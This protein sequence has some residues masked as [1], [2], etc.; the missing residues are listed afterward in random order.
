MK[1]R[2]ILFIIFIAISFNSFSQYVNVGA[3][4]YYGSID[5]NGYQPQTYYKYQCEKDTLINGDIYSKIAFTNCPICPKF[6]VNYFITKQNNKIYYWFKNGKRLLFDLN[7]KVG[8]TVILDVCLTRINKVGISVDSFV[9]CKN[10]VTQISWK[11]NYLNPNDSLKSIEANNNITQ[12]ITFTDRVIN[13][14]IQSYSYSILSLS[15]Y[16]QMEGGNYLSCYSDS[17]YSYKDFYRGNLACDY[18]NTGINETSKENELIEVFPNPANNEFTI[19]TKTAEKLNAQLFDI[20][21]KEVSEKISFINSATIIT[22]EISNGIYFLKITNSN[23]GLMKMQKIVI[24][25]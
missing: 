13:A 6:S 14:N 2:K 23:F 7:A 3:Q 4:W 17:N 1:H 10:V 20:T 8:D 9:N 5:A 16:P 18:D 21:G 24:V 11:K 22:Q 19:Q 25:K 15:G 12:L